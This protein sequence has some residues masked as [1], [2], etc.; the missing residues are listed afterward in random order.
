M[1]QVFVK[2]ANDYI[3]QHRNK[4]VDRFYIYA[5]RR[6]TTGEIFYVGKGCGSRAWSRYG[7]N[8]YWQ[9][10]SNKH[11]YVVEILFDN[12]SEEISLVLEKEIIYVFRCSGHTLV[13]MTSGGESPVFTEE[14]RKL[15]SLARKGKKHS[16]EHRANLRKSARRGLRP[17]LCGINNYNADLKVY[18]FI[19]QSGEVFIGNRLE[20]CEKYK[21]SRA[22]LRGLFLSTPRKTSQGWKLT[23]EIKND[24]LTTKS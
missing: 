15:M 5:H 6:E 19:H 14:S 9:N 12:L 1:Q 17:E 3:I 2:T 22:L 24:C 20:L 11:G 4:E 10:V 23:G 13:N 18:S 21:L 16:A 8:N 7:R